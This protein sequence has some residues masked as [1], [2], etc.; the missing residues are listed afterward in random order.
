MPHEGRISLIHKDLTTETNVNFIRRNPNSPY[1]TESDPPSVKTYT[2]DCELR[3]FDLLPEELHRG[4]S[5]TDKVKSTFHTASTPFVPL[6]IITEFPTALPRDYKGIVPCNLIV[7]RLPAVQ[8]P[9]CEYTNKQIPL[10]EVEITDLKIKLHGQTDTRAGGHG[11]CEENKFDMI[12]H[13]KSFTAKVDTEL[14]PAEEQNPG[15]KVIFAALGE[16]AQVRLPA[17]LTESFSTY[18][19]ASWYDLTIELFLR[20]RGEEKYCEVISGQPIEILPVA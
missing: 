4:H 2:Y 7:K 5:F 12:E 13:G 6:R 14:L 10:E 11:A 1:Y 20:A 9:K 15:E 8:D 19:I 16:W 17:D 18:N 3:S